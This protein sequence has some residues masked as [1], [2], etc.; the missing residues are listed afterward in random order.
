MDKAAKECAKMMEDV[1]KFEEMIQ[2]TNNNHTESLNKITKFFKA[3]IDA[4]KERENKLMVKLDEVRANK[5]DL[6]E[7]QVVALKGFN[8]EYFGF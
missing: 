1:L 6:F 3:M 8:K 2:N 5:T 4:L 7:K